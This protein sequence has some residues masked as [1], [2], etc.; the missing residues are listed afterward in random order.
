L[1]VV[2]LIRKTN[3]PFSGKK[4]GIKGGRIK[5]DVFDNSSMSCFLNKRDEFG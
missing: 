2:V 5:S 3:V 1:F 4:K